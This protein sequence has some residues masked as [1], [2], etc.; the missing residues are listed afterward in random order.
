M[1]TNPSKEQANARD[2]IK[3]VERAIV[4]FSVSF[5]MVFLQVGAPDF[6]QREQLLRLDAF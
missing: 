6:I 2:R 1:I 3:N 4:S 5:L